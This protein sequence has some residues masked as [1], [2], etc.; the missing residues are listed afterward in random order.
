[1][2]KTTKRKLRRK[3]L[4]RRKR[5][6]RLGKRNLSFAITDMIHTSLHEVNKEMNAFEKAERACDDT[7]FIYYKLR[8]NPNLHPHI[9]YNS[10]FAGFPGGHVQMNESFTN[11]QAYN[12]VKKWRSSVGKILNADEEERRDWKTFFHH[13]LSFIKNHMKHIK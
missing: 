2:N 5:N 4:T 9:H 8:S 13:M 12:M 11:K 3:Q 10:S 7:F 6:S 1:M